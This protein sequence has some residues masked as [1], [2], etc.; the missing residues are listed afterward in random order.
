VVVLLFVLRRHFNKFGVVCLTNWAEGRG[1]VP[2]MAIAAD[3]AKI[4][5]GLALLMQYFEVAE[6]EYSS[7]PILILRY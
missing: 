7:A 4:F 2:F 5:H 3:G 1:L 6:L